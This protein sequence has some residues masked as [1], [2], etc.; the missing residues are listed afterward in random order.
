MKNNKK[1][2]VYTLV[3]MSIL[4]IAGCYKADTLYPSTDSVVNKEVSFVNDIIPIFN[5]KCLSII[6]I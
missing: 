1:A 5:Q 4:I 6:H 3:V 2:I